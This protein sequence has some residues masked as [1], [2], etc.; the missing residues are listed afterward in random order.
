MDRVIL[1]APD[2]VLQEIS[3]EALE[4]K[5]GLQEAYKMENLKDVFGAEQIY[6]TQGSFFGE[7]LAKG[8][9]AGY[10]T[11]SVR[12]GVLSLIDDSV[13]KTPKDTTSAL[14]KLIKKTLD[15]DLFDKKDRIIDNLNIKNC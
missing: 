10:K 15:E 7:P 4:L 9:R 3:P 1:N 12:K 2:E 5:R 14:D 13:K 6:G 11:G 8:G